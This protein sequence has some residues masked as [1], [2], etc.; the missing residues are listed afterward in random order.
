MNKALRTTSSALQRV[1]HRLHSTRHAKIITLLSFTIL[2]LI[3]LQFQYLVFYNPSKEIGI[4]YNKA[5]DSHGPAYYE[6]SDVTIVKAD[7]QK[8]ENITA[9]HIINDYN[10]DEY[11]KNKDFSD[12]T[13]SESIEAGLGKYS[14]MKKFINDQLIGSILQCKPSFGPINNKDHYNKSNHY[15]TNWDGKL[16]VLSGKLRENNGVD[17]IRSKNYLKSYFLLKDREHEHLKNSHKVFLEKMPEK[18]PEEIESTIKGNGILYAGGGQYNWLVL[19]SIKMLRDL[20][21]KLPIEVFIP[22]EN[23]YSVDLCDRVFPVFGAKCILMSNYIDTKKIKIKGYQLKSMALLLTSFENVLMLDSDNL[24]LKNPD[25]LFINEPFIS[26]PLVIWPDFWRRSTSPTFYDIANITINETNQIRFSYNDE[27]DHPEGLETLDDYNEKVSYH[28]LEGTFPEASSE[29]GQ[30]LI[31]KKIH[32]KTLFLSLY[33]NFYGPNYYYPLFSQG[34]AGEGDK[35]TILAAAHKFGLPY[36]QV[37]EY[38]REYGEIRDDNSISIAAMGQYDPILDY[39]QFRNPES[40]KDTKWT[41]DRTK[42][43]YNMHRYKN[44]EMLFLH[45]NQPKLYPWKINGKGFRQIHDDQG[46]RRRLYSKLLIK[47]L[48]YDFELK[49]WEAMKWLICDHGD[50]Q[51]KGL[52]DPLLWCGK[53]NEQLEFLQTDKL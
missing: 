35:E 4:E 1:I 7:P 15:P 13:N 33:Y 50:F 47:E 52:R 3:T 22:N 14:V 24:P 26:K 40:F 30:V 25:L 19:L 12:Y 41:Y 43:N 5:K 42:D 49:I 20:G 11:Y 38:I 34:Q 27:R 16:P 39:I 29:T 46:N 23:E 10:D 45:C 32:A 37:Q 44:S 53:V 8:N 51:V 6:T 18:F 2:I 31:N 28:D 36:Y 21:S 48:G 9:D 17:P